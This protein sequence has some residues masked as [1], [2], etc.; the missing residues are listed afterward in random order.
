MKKFNFFLVAALAH[1]FFGADE[2]LILYVVCAG[3]ETTRL[4]YHQANM[5]IHSA[6]VLFFIIPELLIA[7]QSFMSY[8]ENNKKKMPVGRG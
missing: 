7:K 1:F 8:E 4:P 5:V 6:P 2:T 3:E